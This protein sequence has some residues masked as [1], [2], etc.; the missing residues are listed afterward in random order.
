M[1]AMAAARAAQHVRAAQ[2]YSDS[3]VGE[4]NAEEIEK[5]ALKEEMMNAIL[6]VRCR[7]RGTTAGK[8]TFE[9]SVVREGV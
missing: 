2:A 6:E 5:E 8:M 7:P 4:Q 9:N 3:H 1:A